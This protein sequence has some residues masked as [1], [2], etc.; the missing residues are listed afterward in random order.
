MN[1]DN[2]ILRRIRHLKQLGTSSNVNEAAA[3]IAA[4]QRLMAQ[5]QIEELELE[6]E[7][8][9]PVEEVV[10][11]EVERAG[12]RVPWRQTI[13]FA[14]SNANS[15]KAYITY[16]GGRAV[17][18]VVGPKSGL[19]TVRYMQSYLV[20]EVNRICD[21]EAKGNVYAD[22]SWRNS[23]RL[24]AAAELSRRIRE[25]VREVRAETKAKALATGLPSTALARI[26][27]LAARVAEKLPKNLKQLPRATVGDHSGYS[28]G[29]AAARNINLGGGRALGKGS[30]ADLRA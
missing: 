8:G 19:A 17:S 30:A 21:L 18:T 26:D 15:C 28:S 13:L 3:A 10:E 14:L 7:E 6:A 5:Y 12:R 29:A 16:G 22:R 2:K 20:R 23:F 24:G 9:T 11:E 1:V 25:A 4:A 27:Q